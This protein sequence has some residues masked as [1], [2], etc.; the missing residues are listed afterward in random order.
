MEQK[1]GNIFRRG[2]EKNNKLAPKIMVK[3]G[4]KTLWNSCFRK[5]KKA[6]RNFII[7]HLCVQM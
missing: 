1:R 5:V 6:V 3:I 4:Q 7:N 2:G